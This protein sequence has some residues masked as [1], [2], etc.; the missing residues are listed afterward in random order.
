[1]QSAWQR[2]KM[3]DAGKNLNRWVSN[4]RPYI[5]T[6]PSLFFHRRE[7]PAY[8]FGSGF[9]W[10]STLAAVMSPPPIKRWMV[11]DSFG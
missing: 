9:N 1:M 2:Q 7:R 11:T 6:L 4:P 3:E 10:M 8:G 5:F